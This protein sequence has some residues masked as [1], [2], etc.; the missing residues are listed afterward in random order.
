MLGAILDLG[1]GFG[2]LW[3]CILGRAFAVRVASVSSALRTAPS[4]SCFSA[5]LMKAPRNQR[6]APY[7]IDSA[8]SF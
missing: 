8:V 1:R 3:R 4:G 7:P 5:A 6:G 2:T